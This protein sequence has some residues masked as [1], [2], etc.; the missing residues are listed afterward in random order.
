MRSCFRL[1]LFC[2]FLLLPTQLWALADVSEFTVGGVQLAMTPAQVE[3]ITGIAAKPKTGP[4]GVV[5]NL[6]ALRRVPDVSGGFFQVTFAREELGGQA[7]NVTLN[8][9]SPD[10]SRSLEDLLAEYVAR[11]GEY[12]TLCV[13]KYKDHTAFHLWWGATFTDCKTAGK[14]ISQKHMYLNLI[15]GVWSEIFLSLKDPEL[16]KRNV[17]AVQKA[18][19]AG[20]E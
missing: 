14:N 7:Y 2:L 11:Y 9:R 3:T 12:D 20:K 5:Y 6:R 16:L 15:K 10:T 4:G 13:K 19:A 1:C 8:T 17:E 18:R